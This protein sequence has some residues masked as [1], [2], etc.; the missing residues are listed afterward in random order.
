MAKPTNLNFI[1]K[2]IECMKDFKQEHIIFLFVLQ[3][4]S[5]IKIKDELETRKTGARG[6]SLSLSIITCI[7]KIGYNF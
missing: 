6:N 7:H 4:N 5:L 3:K 2:A 1:M